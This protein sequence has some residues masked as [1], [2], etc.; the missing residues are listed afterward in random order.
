VL[1]HLTLPGMGDITVPWRAWL[2]AAL[3]YGVIFQA[4][5][6]KIEA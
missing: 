2:T 4:E 1:I 3:L 5:E 6:P